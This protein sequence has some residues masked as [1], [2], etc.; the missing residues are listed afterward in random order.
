MSEACTHPGYPPA[1]AAK[2]RTIYLPYAHKRFLL[3]YFTTSLLYYF[4]TLLLPLPLIL[5]SLETMQTV[6]EALLYGNLRLT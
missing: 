1:K 6:S 2:L 3:Y 4:T 5:L